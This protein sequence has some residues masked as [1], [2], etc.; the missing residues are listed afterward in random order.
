M[1]LSMRISCLIGALVLVLTAA[2]GFTA[3]TV[4]SGIVENAA[5]DSLR[6]QTALGA[7]LVK[8]FID[9]R[10][11]ILQEVAS[12]EEIRSMNTGDVPRALL[13]KIVDD[14]GFLDIALIE[15]DGG[16]RYLKEDTVTNLGDR[17]YIKAAVAGT[18]SI[19]DVLISRVTGES[20][21][22]FAVPVKDDAGFIRGAL[23]GR[24]N[25]NALYDIIKNIKPGSGGYAYM[26]NE[27][28]TIIS[29][30]DAGL[31]SRQYN[32]V[33]AARTDTSAASLAAAMPDILGTERGF[34]TYA[35]NGRDTYAAYGPMENYPGKLIV[36]ARQD[37][38]FADVARLFTIIAGAGLGLLFAGIVIANFIGRSVAKPVGI[39]ARTLK[40]ISEGEGDLT[41]RLKTKSQDELGDL[42]RYFNK[43]VAKIEE[44]VIVIKERAFMLRQTGDELSENMARTAK[45]VSDINDT[46]T[47]V[48]ARVKEQSESV[49][50]SSSAMALITGN[51]DSLDAEASQQAQS[52]EQSAAAITQ[53]LAN[54]KSAAETLSGNSRNVKKLMEAF[55]IGRDRIAAVA[56]DI[57][58]IAGESEG[59]LEI[60]GVM[61][62]IA[63]QTNLLS[64]N[65]AIEAAHAGEA[66]K[67]FA[68]V[69]DEIRKLAVSS[70]EQSKTIGAV[71]KKIALSIDK[72]TASTGS[73]LSEFEAIDGGI[74]T[75][76]RQEELI[77]GALES[78]GEGSR[79]I[80]EEIGR[81]RE[82]TR[83]VKGGT[84]EMLERG[85][86]VIKESKNLEG[87]SSEIKYSMDCMAEAAGSIIGSVRDVNEASGKT[88]RNI[89][90]LAEEVTRF[91]VSDRAAAKSLAQ[92]YVWDE[93]FATG[94]EMIDSQ[95]RTLFDALNRLLA[96][97]QSG[98]GKA[99]LKKALDFLNDYTIKHFFEEEQLQLQAKYPDYQNHHRL[100]EDF[101]VTVRQLARRRIMDGTDEKLIAEVKKKIGA[102]LV[103]HI[104]GQ[105]IKLGAY[106]QSPH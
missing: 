22:M 37:E 71:L 50:T 46:I 60:N 57:Q 77:R 93:S 96:A 89:D 65:A 29:H 100:H 35:F 101:K 66:G 61:E 43:T 30:P 52:V 63:S 91:K 11:R 90:S 12:R 3:I 104:K 70:S 49:R 4:S 18:P 72:I 28:G 8:L 24:M 85:A 36:T 10:T 95:H 42:A 81:L 48:N 26:V 2:F 62:N 5:R 14:S 45:S 106:L 59:L 15:P 99:E 27:K 7:D 98:E 83:L 94:N 32:P 31:V 38:L 55:A 39:A 105:D 53:M 103:V 20:V 34:L 13:T 76:A 21:L 102:W 1:K 19:S 9:S 78:Q 68:V 67:G 87:L 33:E 16:A 23:A 44:L 58:G 40:D 97:M 92:P 88:K 73:V 79:L 17:E 41:R 82:I 74:N 69:A 75:V 6:I 56:Q 25:G 84:M 47:N 80:I 51:I 54:V 64:M 86:S